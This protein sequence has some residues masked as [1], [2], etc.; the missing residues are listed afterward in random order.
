VTPELELQTGFDPLLAEWF[1]TRFERPTEPQV[2]GWPEIRAGRD[3]L[4][5]APTGSG[6]TLA[7]FLICLDRLVRAARRGE[8]ADQTEVVYVSPLKAL[9]NDIHKNL[10]IPLAEISELAA[11][12][13]IPFAPIRTAVRTGDTP[14]AD[15]LKMGKKPPHILVTTPES[16]YILL[17]AEKSRGMLRT[18]RTVIVDEIHAVADDKRG[19]HL[20]LSLARLDALAEA[21]KPQRIGLSATVKPIEQVAEF[22]SPAARI[23]NVGHRRAMDLA[24]EV[25][26]DELGPIAS[27]EMWA[28]IYDRVAALILGHRT[29]L[30]FV[31]TRRLA[32]RV[33]HA[34][35]ERL[36]ENVVLPHHGSLSRALRLNAEARLK[37]G[38]LRAVVATASLELGIDIGTVDLVCQIG[39]PRSI[40]VGLQ[41]VGRSGHWVGAKPQGRFFVTTRDELIECAALVRAIRSGD[42]DRIEIPHCPLDILAQQIV[43]ECAARDWREDDLFALIRGTYPYRDFER[44]QFDAIIQ[45]LSDGIATQRGRS[46]AYLH[47]D[48]VNGRVRG[49]RG[50][51]LAA[52]TSGGAIPETANYSVVA[53]PDGKV[54]GTVDEDFAVESLA[55]D[56]FLLG[57]SSWRIKRIEP[58]RVRVEDAHGAPPNVPFWNGEAPGRTFELSQAVGQVRERTVSE[59]EQASEFLTGECGLSDAGAK[60]AIAYVLAGAAALNALPTQQTVVAERFFDEA[61]G[62]QLII[63][64]PF[65]SRINRAW[66][67]ALRKRF[68]RSFNFELQAAATDNG[69]NISLTEQH[70]FPLELVFEF[71]KP[72]TVEHVLTQAMLDAPMFAARWRW[73]A[74]RALAILRFQG[75]RKVPPPIQR[76]RA[77]DLLASVFPDQVACAENLTGEIRIPDHPLVNETIDNCLHEAM[78]LDG[79]TRILEAME[80]GAIRKVAIDNAEPSPFSHEILNANPYAYLDDAPLEERRARAV[81]LRQTLRTD[82]T[83]AAGI[84]DP[85]AIATVA[86]ESWPDVRNAD[87]LHDALLTLI[88]VPAAEQ[89]EEFFKELLATGRAHRIG[90]FWVA[91]ERQHLKDEPLPIVRGWMESIGPVT[92]ARLAEILGFEVEPALFQLESEGQAMRGRFSPDLAADQVEWCNRR[93]LARIHRLTLGKLRREIEPVTAAQLERFLFRWQHV[94]PGSRLHG[95]DGTLQIIRQLQGYEISAAA[96]E[97]E[98][99]S[100]RV[101]HYES[102]F[103]DELCLSGEVMWARLSPHPAFEDPEPHRVRPTRSAPIAIFLRE[104][105]DWLEGETHD[106][107]LSHPAAELL[108][109]LRERGAAFFKDL[110]RATGRLAS[111]VEDGLWELVAAGLV[112]ADGFENLRSLIDPKRRRGEGRGRLARPRHAAGRWALVRHANN[113]VTN[114]ARAAAFADQLLTRWGVIFRDLLARETLAP[115]WRDLLPVLRRKEAQGEIRGGRFVAGFSGEQFARPEALDLLRAVR[116][117]KE[118]E[119]RPEI[120]NA[121]PLNLA[122]IILP[123]PRVSSLMRGF[124]GRQPLPVSSVDFTSGSADRHQSPALSSSTSVPAQTGADRVASRSGASDSRP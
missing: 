101:A 87:E 46:G 5:S 69:I 73:N 124:A 49:R 114:E 42:L 51:R 119:V 88:L 74:S 35:A 8:L 48:Q 94:L 65:G 44:A 20:A 76:M 97:S 75:G 68:C 110:V 83:A 58:G 85:D 89:W 19:S 122:G 9:S 105:A 13:G 118:P 11:S 40:A 24:V 95:A 103:L 86:A 106:P 64:A 60:Q 57:T 66:G 62:M 93:I 72:Q 26:R 56:I 38:E 81:Q 12:R 123:G 43:A 121:D 96:W 10:E 45:M 108:A 29:T 98:V 109:Q 15:R 116:R 79:L 4:I 70:A 111:E 27:N 92:A 71:L 50:A 21:G 39:S 30:V 47:R 55:G 22:L 1:K 17:T 115:P 61:G 16:L 53:E 84:L 67:L 82:A 33:A 2:L 90:R 78:D 34:L 18:T 113:A 117:D 32:E 100:R 107:V 120:P 7:A 102:E 3:V 31:N 6:K 37:N 59:G 14:A 77:D 91:T 54:V 41:R 80:S 52:I 104:S 99:L 36:G 112:T 63:H 28:E 25:P 23:V